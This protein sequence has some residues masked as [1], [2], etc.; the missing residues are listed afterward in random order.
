MNMP[1][2]WIVSSG[3]FFIFGVLVL[4]GLLVAVVLAIKAL[5][6]VQEKVEKTIE[7]A[8]AIVERLEGV[9]KTAQDTVDSIGGK[10]RGIAGKFENLATKVFDKAEPVLGIAM[11]AMTGMKLYQQFAHMRA[12]GQEEATEAASGSDRHAAARNKKTAADNEIRA[13]PSG[14]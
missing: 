7:R 6:S 2:W 10:A 14:K 8:E 12:Q 1:D 5:K 4:L 9:S 11:L 13:L 3:I